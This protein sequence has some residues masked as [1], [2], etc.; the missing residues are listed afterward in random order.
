MSVAVNV[1]IFRRLPDIWMRTLQIGQNLFRPVRVRHGFELGATSRRRL[2]GQCAVVRLHG[3]LRPLADHLMRGD[4]IAEAG[5]VIE[6]VVPGQRDAG[7]VF[8]GM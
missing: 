2:V 7:P 6:H 5:T 3:A 8:R 4:D 1:D